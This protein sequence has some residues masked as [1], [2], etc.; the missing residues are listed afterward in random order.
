MYVIFPAVLGFM[1]AIVNLVEGGTFPTSIV[2]A[3]PS[4]EPIGVP[5]A[6]RNSRDIEVPFNVP[7]D[8]GDTIKVHTYI[9]C[10]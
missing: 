5:I 1:D 7:I 4:D 6:N 2:L 8:P 9:H 10:A 3:M